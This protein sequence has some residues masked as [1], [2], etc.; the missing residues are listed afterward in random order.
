MNA[1]V[2]MFEDYLESFRS[3]TKVRGST[4][5]EKLNFALSRW[6]KVV[7]D[8]SDDE[9]NYRMGFSD[10]HA[11]Y[12]KKVR[13]LVEITSDD[14]M[15]EALNGIATEAAEAFISVGDMIPSG[16]LDGMGY[17]ISELELVTHE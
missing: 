16:V 8:S 7:A 6:D 15:P 1:E 12:A 10:V 9:S 13:E 11:K 2:N 5:S 4:V 3:R 17:I 14:N